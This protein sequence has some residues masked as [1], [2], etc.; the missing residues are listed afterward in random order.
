M[1]ISTTQEG[2][3]MADSVEKDWKQF[4]VIA[5]GNTASADAAE[6]QC[7]FLCG[8]K[9]GHRDQLGHLSKVLGGGCED[10]LVTRTIWAS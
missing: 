4:I 2:R 3:L 1:A 7:R 6:G 8:P 10:E 5:R 9:G